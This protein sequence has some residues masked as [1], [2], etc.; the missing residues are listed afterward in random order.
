[1]QKPTRPGRLQAL[2]ESLQAELQHTPW[3]QK[4]ERHSMPE[5]HSAAQ[6]ALPHELLMQV[7]GGA[8]SESLEQLLRQV[9]PLHA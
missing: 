1:M 6:G 9:V 4:P 3:A 2:Q 8:Q 5:L 7:L